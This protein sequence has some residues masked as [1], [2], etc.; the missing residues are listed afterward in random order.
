L[1]RIVTAPVRV[2]VAVG[3]K[4]TLSVQKPAGGMVLGLTA[5]S[6][7]CAK[8][9]LAT[10]LTISRALVPML[11]SRAFCTALVVP[12]GCGAN[13]KLDGFNA[14]PGPT[15]KLNLATKASPFPPLGPLW[16]APGVVGKS[17]EVVQPAI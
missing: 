6:L 14:R 4:V 7:V 15:G 1:S 10:M 5:Q 13:V 9:P 16:N 12:T 11:L 17:V 2:P 8:S 3:A